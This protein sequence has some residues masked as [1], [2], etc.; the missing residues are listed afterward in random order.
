MSDKGK[1]QNSEILQRWVEMGITVSCLAI[2]QQIGDESEADRWVGNEREV[3][4]L[5]PQ[6]VMA[7]A[8]ERR[9]ALKVIL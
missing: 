3:D 2:R 9:T 1:L 6:A 8:F 4:R 5:S 7:F